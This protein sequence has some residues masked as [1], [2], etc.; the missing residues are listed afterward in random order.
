MPTEWTAERDAEIDGDFAPDVPGPELT[1]DADVPGPS[2]PAVVPHVPIIPADPLEIDVDY[3]GAHLVFKR[4]DGVRPRQ[5]ICRVSYI[6]P[7]EISKTSVSV[8]CQLHGCAICKKKRLFPEDYLSRVKDTN[9]INN[10]SEQLINKYS[11]LMEG[12]PFVP[13]P[14]WGVGNEGGPHNKTKPLNKEW[15]IAGE[16]FGKHQQS[17]HKA[18][19]S[20]MVLGLDQ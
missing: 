13:Q 12:A 16:G 19:F 14:F 8:Y 11:R 9:K 1:V 17:A 6:N 20:S 18:L 3:A 2:V 7:F 4:A 15:L 5:R 10:I